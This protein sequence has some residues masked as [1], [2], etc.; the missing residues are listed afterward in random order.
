MVTIFVK[1]VFSAPTLGLI[2]ISLSFKTTIMGVFKAPALFSA[3][4]AS[5][6]VIDPSPITE[7]TRKF[8]PECFRD[9]AIPVAA[10]I[11]VEACPAPNTS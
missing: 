4:N 8:L 7:T 10:E 1:Y 9:R 5:P 3:S 2:D 6:P 11:E